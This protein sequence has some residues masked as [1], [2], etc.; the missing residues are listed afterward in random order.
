MTWKGQILYKSKSCTES[1]IQ[2]EP[3]PERKKE[4]ERMVSSFFLFSWTSWI[5]HIPLTDIYFYVTITKD[6]TY[7]WLH[8][9]PIVLYSFMTS[10]I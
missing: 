5:S 2:Q 4:R 8:P 10:L 1:N 9:S 7:C 6:K 3:D